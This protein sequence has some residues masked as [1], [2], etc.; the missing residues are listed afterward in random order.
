[1][2]IRYICNHWKVTGDR[3]QEKNIS[4]PKIRAEFY[5]RLF[6]FLKFNPEITNEGFEFYI[7]DTV[8]GLEFS[9]GLTGFGAGYFCDDDSD[10]TIAVITDL[11]KQV[12]N[13]K[14][15]LVPCQIEYKHDFGKS[16][17]GCDNGEIVELDVE[18]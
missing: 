6:S 16:I 9:A 14:L 13:P 7:T 11:D 3:I 8:T 18:E 17:L 15:S 4:T 5:V 2:D 12:F 1:M 10:E